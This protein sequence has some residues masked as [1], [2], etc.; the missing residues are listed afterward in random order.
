MT[1]L[2]RPGRSHPN[3]LRAHRATM[4]SEPAFILVTIVC[5]HSRSYFA[6]ACLISSAN[7]SASSSETAACFP[8][9]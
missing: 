8:T 3:L 4:A 1:M 6:C 9:E 2:R 7:A 5:E